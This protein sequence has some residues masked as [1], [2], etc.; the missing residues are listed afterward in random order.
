VK[1]AVASCPPPRR[2]ITIV[3]L[4][5]QPDQVGATP[6]GRPGNL[7]QTVVFV[8][9]QIKSNTPY[10]AQDRQLSPSC[11]TVYSFFCNVRLASWLYPWVLG[12]QPA[13]DLLVLN[14]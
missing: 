9:F 13:V 12:N 10:R 5:N 3:H 14:L 8:R 6:L 7:K 11:C 1:G 4:Y 2:Q